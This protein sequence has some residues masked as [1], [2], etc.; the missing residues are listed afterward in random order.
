MTYEETVRTVLKGE[1]GYPAA[2]LPYRNMPEKLYYIGSLP[3]EGPCAAVVGAR[4]CSGYG[5]NEALRISKYL[6]ERGV[7]VVS[8][9]AA[10]IDMS[11]Q[12]G[13]LLAGGKTYAVLGCGPD[14]CYPKSAAPLYRRIAERGGILSE[15]PPGTAPLKH[16]FPMRNRIIS[17]LADAVIVIEARARSGSLITADHAL[18]QGKAV[19]ALPG[20]IGD[21]LAE[22][23]NFLI[24]QGAGII[25]SLEA[26]YL[27]IEQISR[28]RQEREILPGKG[29]SRAALRR[30]DASEAEKKRREEV[31]RSLPPEEGAVWRCLTDDPAAADVIAAASGISPE[32]ACAA[33]VSLW[34][35]DLAAEPAKGQFVRII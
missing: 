27:E 25:W 18:E 24:A 4:M 1:E 21:P 28:R 3:G 7:L 2:L 30:A 23:C 19:F 29:I 9:M 13:A 26:L 16:H 12:E 32:K 33:L 11:A 14:V 20:R 10:G 5:R 22:G 34:M 31:L 15:Y 6:A 35:K 17:G 8:G